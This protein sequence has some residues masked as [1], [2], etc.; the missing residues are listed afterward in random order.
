M[1]EHNTSAP[2]AGDP[3]RAME[4]ALTVLT[5]V[6]FRVTERRPHEL[7]LLGL[8][9]NSTSASPLT[10]ASQIRLVFEGRKVSLRAELGGLRTMGLFVTLFPL[11]LAATLGVVFLL[12]F[13][14]R[15]VA[16]APVG[17]GLIW[18]VLGPFITQW[19]GKR[20]RWA[21]DALVENIAAG[22]AIGR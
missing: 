9:W 20:V 16:L 15:I 22:S 4:L 11:G 18:I 1:T 19:Y 21:L 5:P 17:P 14:M 12:A 13:G 7:V 6:G 2:L 3:A 10:G 8:G